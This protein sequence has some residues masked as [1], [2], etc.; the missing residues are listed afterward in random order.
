MRLRAL[1]VILLITLFSATSYASQEAD[2]Q[3]TDADSLYRSGKLT[4]AEKRLTEILAAEP[5][6]VSSL[7]LM[8]E[9]LSKDIRRLKE[10]EGWY[11]KTLDA[12]GGD[13]VVTTKSTYAIAVLYMKMGRYEDAISEFA[14]LVNKF[15]DYYDVPRAYNQM[16]VASYRLDRYDEALGYFKAAIKSDPNLLEAVFNMKTLQGQ[17]SLLNSARYYQR[18][19]DTDAAI[20]R[21]N[22][23]LERYPNYVAA[24][25]QLGLVYL[26]K[27][28]Y[29]QAIKSLSRARVL[30]PKYLG[31]AEVPYQLA[32][33]YEGRG[34]KG[35][36]DTALK[37][38]LQSTSYKDSML[39]AGIIY[40]NMGRLADAEKAFSTMT[41]SGENKKVQ[42][43]A[44]YQTGILYK[45]KSDTQKA[46]TAFQKALEL[47]PGEE[48][49]KSPPL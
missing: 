29:D 34:G 12:C 40:M 33:A 49:Y 3:Y 13:R 16:G 42:A 39:K 38:Y 41:A 7:F 8:G 6:H 25:Y 24:W 45:K 1:I 17:L 5:K 43:E 14:E 46:A 15:P 32:E 22:D 4:G 2:D 20:A 9:I 21:Y 27:K 36:T 18:L 26:G 19:G 28:D 11:K 30:N 37:L 23:A 44:W 31:D 10:A 47:A 35:D 48:R